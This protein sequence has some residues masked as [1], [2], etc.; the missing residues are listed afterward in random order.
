MKQIV[1]NHIPFF[2]QNCVFPKVGNCF[3]F[4]ST[5]FSN[6]HQFFSDSDRI[7]NPLS[8]NSNS[9]GNLS[10]LHFSFEV[11]WGFLVLWEFF[12]QKVSVFLSLRLLNSW[13]TRKSLPHLPRIPLL[14]PRVGYTIS[15]ILFS[16]LMFSF[17]CWNK[18]SSS[19]LGI[20]VLRLRPAAFYLHIWSTVYQYIDV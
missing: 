18:P 7:T 14:L 5:Q 2:I 16:F 1:Y 6:Y 17:A 8:K 10:A 11:W 15:R 9:L 12:W 19:S 4:S 3:Y 20:N 13:H